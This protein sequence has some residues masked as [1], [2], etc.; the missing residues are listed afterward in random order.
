MATVSFEGETHDEIVGKVR[1]WLE[2]VDAG[3][4]DMAAMINQQA[5]ITKDALRIIAQS[6]PG[7]ISDSEVLKSLTK[8]GYKATDATRDAALT[9]LTSLESA[10]G[11][12]MVKNVADQGSKA[13]FK[14]NSAIAKQFLKAVTND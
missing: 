3:E 4:T 14:M 12:S 7:P 2:S 1:A 8:M 11:G 5:A 9:A 13:M 6:A 10:T